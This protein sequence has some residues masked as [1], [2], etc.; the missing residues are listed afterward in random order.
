MS[1]GVKKLV[2][3]AELVSF[4][5]LG[6]LSMAARVDT[7]A[8]VSA[9]AVTSVRQQGDVLEAVFFGDPAETVYRFETYK[10]SLVASSTGQVERRFKVRLLVVL[11]GKKIRAS[12]TL[13]DRSARTYPV[14]IGR[15][16]L[17][18]KFLV[19]VKEGTA[20]RRKPSLKKLQRPPTP[21]GNLKTLE[22]ELEERV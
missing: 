12:F 22:E 20:F 1:V 9:I 6:G 19:D 3:R 10:K 2:G 18:G 7:G 21:H 16:V 11:G 13:A 14:L 17:L 8:K 4:P 15:N 5:E